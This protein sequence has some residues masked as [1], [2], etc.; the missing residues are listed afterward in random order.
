MAAEESE[1]LR[2]WAIVLLV[3][4][5]PFLI[6]GAAL[7]ASVYGIPFGVP[8]LLATVPPAG[9]AFRRA[10]RRATDGDARLST[11]M[12]V[13]ATVLAL[14]LISAAV[15]GAN[16]LDT[17]L[18]LSGLVV[19]ALWIG[20]LATAGYGVRVRPRHVALAST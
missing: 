4:L 1:T 18:D 20:G 11:W 14:V 16:D 7:T 5:A 12:L 17:A 2:R 3:L 15:I 8:I 19:A 9:R 6:V 13:F 10:R